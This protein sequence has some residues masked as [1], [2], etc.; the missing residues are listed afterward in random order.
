MHESHTSGSKRLA[1]DTTNRN[2]TFSKPIYAARLAH[3][4]RPATQHAAKAVHK[5]ITFT[6]LRSPEGSPHIGIKYSTYTTPRICYALN[7]PTR[8]LNCA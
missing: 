5:L 1:D 6:L 4:T 3:R 7:T 2:S 8:H